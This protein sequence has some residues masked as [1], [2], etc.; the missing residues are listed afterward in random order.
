MVNFSAKGTTTLAQFKEYLGTNNLIVYYERATLIETDISSYITKDTLEDRVNLSIPGTNLRNYFFISNNIANINFRTPSTINGVTYTLNNDKSI[1][2]SGTS[3]ARSQL[4][5][6]RLTLNAG[7]YTLANLGDRTKA[8]IFAVYSYEGQV[9]YIDLTNRPD[10]YR[11]F[12]LPAQVELNITVDVRQ[13]NTDTTGAVIK[14]MLVT[15]NVAPTVYAPYGSMVMVENVAKAYIDSTWTYEGTT[16]R[17]FK[18]L[19]YMKVSSTRT[20]PLYMNRYQ[21]ISDG[22]SYDTDWDKV[23]YNYSSGEP[24]IYVTNKSYTSLGQ[25][26]EKEGNNPII[27]PLAT[28]VETDISEYLTSESLTTDT[29][30]VEPNGTLEF[31]NTY[32]QAV[33]NEVAYLFNAVTLN[34][35]VDS[36]GNT[37]VI[38]TKQEL[39]EKSKVVANPTLSGD[40]ATLEGAE[41]DGIKYKVGGGGKLYRHVINLFISADLGFISFSIE[42]SS[43]EPFTVATLHDFFVEKGYTYSNNG[44]L[45]VV[46]LSFGGFNYFCNG[47][48]ALS[49]T[50]HQNRFYYKCLYLS[51]ETFALTDSISTPQSI[52]DIIT[53]V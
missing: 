1:S 37:N 5:S 14:T 28:P 20:L 15:G 53:E 13:P 25:W 29:L 36:N 32:N 31:L 21:C 11:T 3:T 39:N 33:P 24:T 10:Y 2:L 51:S 8:D 42:N 27:Y 19:S 44:Y 38:A 43:N 22:S 34:N 17:I 52:T 4:V 18:P 30:D 12:T 47:I 50:N 6:V 16:L 45:N 46:Q 40:E 7:T 49:G 23:I 35:I 48:S 9:V 26:I 41:I